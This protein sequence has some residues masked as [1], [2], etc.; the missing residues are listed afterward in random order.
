MTTDQADHIA[1]H[2]TMGKTASVADASSGATAVPVRQPKLLQKGAIGELPAG[3]KT[4]STMNLSTKT[5][6]ESQKTVPV[7]D[8]EYVRRSTDIAKSHDQQV[9][10][11]LQDLKKAPAIEGYHTSDQLVKDHAAH[12][13]SLD[14]GLKGGQMQK[15]T[16]GTYTRTTEHT[17]F[18]SKYY[19]EHGRAPSKAAY[20][21]EAQHELESGKASH[22]A[23]DVYAQLKQ[24]ETAAVQKVYNTHQAMHAQLDHEY[25]NGKPNPDYQPAKTTQTGFVRG[26]KAAKT[27]TPVATAAQRRI[28]QIDTIIS[29]AQK[30]GTT[31]SATQMRAL[32]QERRRLQDVA[33]GKTVPKTAPKPSQT[34]RFKAAAQKGK[35]TEKPAKTPQATS[36]KSPGKS[37]EKAPAQAASANEIVAETS[38]PISRPKAAGKPVEREPLV[39]NNKSPSKGLN[40][41]VASAADRIRSGGKLN[42]VIDAARR[43]HTAFSD[44]ARSVA[45]KKVYSL[46][47]GNLLADKFDTAYSDYLA[48]G[49]S[50]EQ[51]IK[52]IENGTGNS[53][54]HQLW[55]QIHKDTG[56]Q[57]LKHG[58]TDAV[59]NET[60]VGRVGQFPGKGYVRGGTG[61]KKSG[62]FSKG[63]IQGAVDEFGNSHDMFKTHA[64]YKAF[65]EKNGGKVLSDPRQILR[66][67]LPSKLEAIENAKGLNG[68]E[69]TAMADGRPA[70]ISVGSKGAPHEFNDY[71]PV[72]GLNGRMVHPDA[73]PVMKALTHVYSAEELNNPLAKANSM[74]KKLVTLNGLVHGKNFALAS[75]RKQGVI[76]TAHA[77]LTANKNLSAR[78]GE[79]NIQ[80]AVEKGG[81]VPFEQ[82]QQDM[83]DKIKSGDTKPSLIQRVFKHGEVPFDTAHSKM[84][85]ALFNKLGN[86][87]QLSAYFHAEK[88][89]IKQGLSADEAA[90]AAG[91]VAKNVSFISSSVESSAEYRKTSRLVAFAGQY[92]KS[93]M[94]EAGTAAGL[95]KDNALSK[96][97]QSA[98]QKEAIKGAIRGTTYLMGMAQL[99]NYATTGHSTFQ[100]KGSKISPVFYVD[101]NTGKEYHLTNWY[102][103]I[104][105]IM[106]MT[107]PQGW[108]NKTSPGLQEIV[109]VMGNHD[110]FTGA[111]I[112]DPN[113]SGVRQIGQILGNTIENLFTPAGF[114]ASNFGK[115]FGKSADPAPVTLARLM[116]YGASTQAQNNLEK[117]IST[118]YYNSL[119]QKATSTSPQ[120]SKLEAAARHDIAKGNKDS[121]NVQ[122]LKGKMS[123]AAYK[124]F[125][126]TG[127]LNQTQYQFDKLSSA[128]KL[129]IVQKYSPQQLKELD[130]S[131][132]VKTVSSNKRSQQTLTRKDGYT[133]Q[134]LQ[135][136][137]D[138]AR[139]S[140]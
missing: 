93:T 4:G 109:R 61:L 33:E 23:S 139:K 48:K 20:L 57:M 60:Y 137:L 82:S 101:K 92:L 125:V 67:T 50:H 69:K 88:Q 104:G 49:G 14:S 15:M 80:R 38:A 97:A 132:L 32:M 51:F 11:A 119:P 122:A 110:S 59:R 117:D 46:R 73:T 53:E 37:P 136:L 29:K 105:D 78:F 138:K 131:G 86:H 95:V 79:A 85:D 103:Q 54:A 43:G 62:G 39:N 64:D 10:A 124:A 114:G 77:V 135:T 6:P 134:Q 115:T 7:S 100:N 75:I 94:H 13:Q 91:Q 118:S 30:Q 44:L 8:E 56:A 22:G 90:K 3:S 128:D 120:L 140:Q 41:L 2:G 18:Y 129:K 116:G 74:A 35:T 28:A 72:Q 68:L 31:K 113:A 65:V 106:H 76:R 26:D 16:D 1:Q 89:F 34:D 52:D 123:D 71:V 58:V 5:I 47:H 12:L 70:V 45:G 27:T 81:V 96:A 130:L 25:M 66:H 108:I 99:L 24:R 9:K 127:G 98:V 102:G 107:N 87:L 112:R 42:P 126:K 40:K 133:S 63:R 121:A 36:E 19:A 111:Q 84:N 83:F 17:P 21:A 55:R